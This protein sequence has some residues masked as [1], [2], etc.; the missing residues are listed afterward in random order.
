MLRPRPCWILIY[1][2]A[3]VCLMA[4]LVSGTRSSK[5]PKPRLPSQ[6]TRGILVLHCETA[7]H[8]FYK[9]SLTE[10]G[11][12]IPLPLPLSMGWPNGRKI[13]LPLPLSM[14]WPKGNLWTLC[15][16]HHSRQYKRFMNRQT[17]TGQAA[18]LC[19]QKGHPPTDMLTLPFWLSSDLGGKKILI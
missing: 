16:H 5:K 4:R 2:S 15:S 10:H 17:E 3:L 14:G 11:R 19:K 7:Y 9:G 8:V 6:E 13:P 18:G 12:K 1:A